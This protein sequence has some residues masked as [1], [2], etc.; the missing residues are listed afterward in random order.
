MAWFSNLSA[1]FYWQKGPSYN[2]KLLLQTDLD[3]FFP[4][5]TPPGISLKSNGNPSLSV[6][7]TKPIPLNYQLPA[8]DS[9]ASRRLRSFISLRTTR[10]W[11]SWVSGGPASEA[12]ELFGGCHAPKKTLENVE[13]FI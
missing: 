9:A 13:A 3:Q 2:S 4:S 11:K 5:Q 10:S 8:A 1:S 12:G 7:F 6:G